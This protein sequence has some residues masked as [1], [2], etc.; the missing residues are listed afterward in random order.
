M[1]KPY[2]FADG[3]NLTSIHVMNISFIS[4]VYQF[5]IKYQLATI[6]NF[7]QKTRIFDNMISSESTV[8]SLTISVISVTNLGLIGA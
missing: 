5:I 1:K 4:S 8:E 7:K 2:R 6:D 3:I